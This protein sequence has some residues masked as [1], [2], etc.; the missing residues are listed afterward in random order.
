[1]AQ[2]SVLTV[3]EALHFH[4]RFIL[5]IVKD[6]FHYTVHCQGVLEKPSSEPAHN[7]ISGYQNVCFFSF[8]VCM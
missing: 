3:L 6:S 7:N 2:F 4:Y 1:M 8:S 5:F